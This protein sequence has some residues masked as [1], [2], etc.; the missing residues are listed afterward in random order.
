MTPGSRGWPCNDIDVGFRF[1]KRE[2]GKCLSEL[3][4]QGGT[5]GSSLKR[6]A[7]VCVARKESSSVEA[8]SHKKGLRGSNFVGGMRGSGCDMSDVPGM[9]P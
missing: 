7:S 9:D 6:L 4:R 1:P 2:V 5:H 3:P 8:G